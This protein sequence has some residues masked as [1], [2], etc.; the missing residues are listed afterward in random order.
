MVEAA[1][2][3][4]FLIHVATPV[5]ECE[6]RDRKGLYAK[7]RRGEIPEFTGIS[8]P[9]EEP[10]D[11]DVR[12]DTTG[13]SIEDCLAEVLDAVV[14]GVGP[15]PFTGLRAGLVTARTLGFVWDVPL[16]GVM[17]L[18]ALA[19]DAATGDWLMF[20]DADEVLVEGDGERLRA[21]T[22]QTWREAH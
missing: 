19:F 15:G 3:V 8:S 5:E 12:V 22:G 11:A 20:L 21:L 9:Y 2:G 4:F 14:A 16:H 10:A 17:S 18:D 13:R 1:G 6:R 7:A